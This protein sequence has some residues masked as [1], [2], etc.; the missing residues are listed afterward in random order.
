[1]RDASK[2]QRKPNSHLLQCKLLSGFLFISCLT[3]N[4]KPN[5]I[6]EIGDT[7][8]LQVPPHTHLQFSKIERGGTFIF[9]LKVNF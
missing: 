2:F 8:K 4:F 9:C 7:A 3:P 6:S 5:C 1:M